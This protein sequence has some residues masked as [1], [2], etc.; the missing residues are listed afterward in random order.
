[1]KL[2][3]P[4]RLRTLFVFISVWSCNFSLYSQY[5]FYDIKHVS[6]IRIQFHQNNWRHTLDSLFVNYGEDGRLLGDIEIDGHQ[7]K[8]VGVRYK[9]YSSFSSNEIKNPFNIELEYGINNQNH[10]GYSKLKLSNVIHDPSFIREV[11]SYEIA[12]KYMPASL[13]NFATVY[14]NDT[15]MGLYT[16]VEAVDKK[17]MAKHFSSDGN[18]FFKGAP[19]QLQYPYGQNA[20]LAFTHGADSSGYMPYYKLESDYFGWSDLFH[21]I[22]VL[23]NDTSNIESVLNVD[24]TLW[25]HAFNYTLVN[26]DSYIGY[27]QNYYLYKD[28]NGQFNP[29]PW[30]FNM[31]FGSFR[32]SDATLLNLSIAKT[33][34]LNPLQILTSNTFSPRP[35]IKNLLV[36]PTYNR[37]YIAHMRT[38]LNENFKNNEYYVLGQQIQ[39]IID[40]YV[41]TDTNKFYSYSDFKKNIDTTTGPSSDQYPGIRDLMEARIAYL[42]TFPGFKGF[43]VISEIQYYP[44]TPEKG[45][46]VWITAKIAKA[47][48]GVLAFRNSSNGIFVKTNLYD[49]GNHNDGSAGD[50]VF[51]AKIICAGN[52]IQYYIYAE[53]DS[54]GSFSPERAEYEFYSIQPRISPGEIVINEFSKNW[55][56]LFNN[57]PEDYNLNGLFL[58]DDKSDMSKW[59]FPDTIICSKK[60]LI[61]WTNESNTPSTF[62]V[63]FNVSSYGGRIFLSDNNLNAVDS[64]KYGEMEAGKTIGR[65][66]NGLGSFVYMRPT[67]S[68]CNDIRTSGGTGFLLYP[69]PARE[70]IVVEFNNHGASFSV[71]IFNSIGQIV[72]NSEILGSE[73]SMPVISKSFDISTFNKGIYILK[74]TNGD[75]VLTK[76]FIVV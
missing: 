42:D 47:N 27:S 18:S 61:V 57:T 7:I 9:G 70:N 48:A 62:R 66:P 15:L 1:L 24:R 52:T 68:H 11:L 73:T 54:A 69:N 49:D 51:G 26:L 55:I 67:F 14:V 33:K 40:S 46:D 45:I 32:N 36:N 3:F 75:V 71:E 30:D 64:I 4:F 21:F 39:S 44:I 60:Y 28:D 58:S 6:E 23:N 17:F 13:A 35:L 74:L 25:M 22:D 76:R 56:E 12:R 63:N 59:V 5:N 41:Q 8:N 50:S 10:Q 38:I 37:M 20:N 65:Y 31:S 53:N 72:I 43:P 34:Q 16:N 29:I 2:T 19:E